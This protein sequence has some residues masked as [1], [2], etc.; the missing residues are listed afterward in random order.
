MIISRLAIVTLFVI[1]ST[2]FAAE[3]GA[4]QSSSPRFNSERL[5]NST[6]NSRALDS[7]TKND[8]ML[9][10]SNTNNQNNSQNNPPNRPGQSEQQVT[11]P[12]Q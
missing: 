5:G 4:E 12:S 8:E 3:E 11:H 9:G 6:Q 2:T 10:I 7:N 1:S